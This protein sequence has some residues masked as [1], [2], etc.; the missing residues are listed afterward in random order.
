MKLRKLIA[1]LAVST[2][3]VSAGTSAFAAT[4]IVWWHAMGG[5]LGDKVNEIAAGFNASQSDYELKP[6]SRATTPRR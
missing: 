3:I 4:E 5:A 1:G 6:F 2:V